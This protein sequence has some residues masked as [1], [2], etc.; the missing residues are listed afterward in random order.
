[1]VESLFEGWPEML[2][3]DRSVLPAHIATLISMRGDTLPPL[4]AQGGSVRAARNLLESIADDAALCGCKVLADPSAGAA[5]RAM[6]FLWNGWPQECE[7]C[8]G[9]ARE[10]DRNYLLGLS[11]RQSGRWQEAKSD[12]QKVDGHPIFEPLGKFA[13]EVCDIPG[14]SELRRFVQLLGMVDYWEAFA[15]VD[16][17]AGM[18]A[19]KGDKK[20][21]DV[22]AAIQAREMELFLEYALEEATGVSMSERLR[23]RRESESDVQKKVKAAAQYK[24]GLPTRRPSSEVPRK[25]EK[26]GPPPSPEPASKNKSI[27]Y[28]CPKCGNVMRVGE[29]ARGKRVKCSSCRCE[30]AIPG[31]AGVQADGKRVGMEI[32]VVCP[33]CRAT[34]LVSPALRGKAKTCTKCG[35]GFL[36]PTR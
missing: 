32:G 5:V 9:M 19:G 18:A 2:K 33:K 20:K 13:R 12:L 27:S 4:L 34:V 25:C 1:M 31:G 29:D 28:K 35:A 21:E 10:V 16:L 6:L 14:Q 15:F 17:C 7:M 26:V 11:R 22:L 36:V 8:A 24:R 30:F 23:L 3:L